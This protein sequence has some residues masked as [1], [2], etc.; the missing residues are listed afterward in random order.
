MVSEQPSTGS[1]LPPCMPEVITIAIYLKVVVCRAQVSIAHPQQSWDSPLRCRT[2]LCQDCEKGTGLS[3]SVLNR[4]IALFPMAILQTCQKPQR[5]QVP[6][7]K[8]PIQ[9]LLRHQSLPRGREI[10]TAHSSGAL[11]EGKAAKP[12]RWHPLSPTA[13]TSSR[14]SLGRQAVPAATCTH[15]LENSD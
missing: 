11:R 14:A 9:H 10:E 3:H 2:Y 12:K 8:N 13:A 4:A 7:R 1:S 6:S 15:T 5:P